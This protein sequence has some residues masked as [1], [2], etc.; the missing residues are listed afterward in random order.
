[1]ILRQR[2]N[3][4][5]FF[6]AGLFAIGTP[7]SAMIQLNA[8]TATIAHLTDRYSVGDPPSLHPF[9]LLVLWA[10]PFIGLTMLII[11]RD[12]WQEGG[13]SSAA[14]SGGN[15]ANLPDSLGAR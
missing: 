7:V 3:M 6:G 8:V 12:Y 9:A 13:Q 15:L 11:G 4:T 5:G 1:M 14:T 10:V 2:L